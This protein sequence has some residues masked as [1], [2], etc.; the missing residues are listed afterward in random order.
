MAYADINI[1][2]YIFL[3]RIV[4]AKCLS[5]GAARRSEGGMR[6]EMARELEERA[7]W[8]KL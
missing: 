3:H 7:A 2:F 6:D 8:G 4:K 1:T 5:R